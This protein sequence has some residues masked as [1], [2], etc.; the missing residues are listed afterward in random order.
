M[1]RSVFDWDKAQNRLKELDEL[2]ANPNLWEDAE[3]AQRLMSERTGLTNQIKKVNDLSSAVSD[4]Y[5]MI[6]LAEA[7]ADETLLVDA[8]KGFAALEKEMDNYELE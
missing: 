8:E 5:D 1:S 6:E 3:K 4:G 2:T 7:E